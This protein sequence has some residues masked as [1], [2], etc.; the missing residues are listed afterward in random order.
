MQI[1]INIS[2]VK[3][4]NTFGDR[5]RHMGYAD[6]LVEDKSYLTGHLVLNI[7]GVSMEGLGHLTLAVLEFNG[8][9]V[10]LEG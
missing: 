1:V 5:L 3:N 9:I 4:Q 2:A 6:R 8:A 10:K 7:K